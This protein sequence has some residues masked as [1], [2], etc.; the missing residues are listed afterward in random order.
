MGN[1]NNA[2]QELRAEREQA[3]APVEKL[4]QAISVTEALNGSGTVT[5]ANQ[6]T[7]VRSAGSRHFGSIAGEK[8]GSSSQIRT[9]GL[10]HATRSSL[11]RTR[12]ASQAGLTGRQLLSSSQ[13]R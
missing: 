12:G 9:S 1:L 3:Q 8:G 11:S 2:L 5:Q 10:K 4:D 6:L 13:L 7:R